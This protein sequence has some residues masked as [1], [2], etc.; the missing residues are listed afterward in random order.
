MSNSSKVQPKTQKLDKT[1][2]TKPMLIEY[3]SLAEH[4]KMFQ[5]LA[6]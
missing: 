1:A 2:Y 4:T 3:G 6:S 5:P